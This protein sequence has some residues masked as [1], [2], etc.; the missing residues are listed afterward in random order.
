MWRRSPWHVPE[1]LRVPDLPELVAA[2]N[3][4]PWMPDAIGA[5]W[6]G[7]TQGRFAVL[8]AVSRSARREATLTAVRLGSDLRLFRGAPRCLG[9]RGR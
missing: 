7:D 4:L 6:D 2:V 9:R 5:I 3:G 1:H 8:V